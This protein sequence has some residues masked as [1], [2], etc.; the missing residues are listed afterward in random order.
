[1]QAL[2]PFSLHPTFPP[3]ST[4][5][6][7]LAVAQWLAKPDKDIHADPYT[8]VASSVSVCTIPV[9][10]LAALDVKQRSPNSV[11]GEINLDM[12]PSRGI[13]SH[14]LDAHSF[15]VGAELSHSSGI[16]ECY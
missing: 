3:G 5:P 16:L 10:L 14:F 2:S 1:M 6:Q 15:P 11:G 9:R 8:G 7:L 12:S 4:A 13:A